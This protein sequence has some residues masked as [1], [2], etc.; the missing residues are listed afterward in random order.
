MSCA[1]A[2]PDMPQ[3]ISNNLPDFLR[4]ISVKV[5]VKDG[6]ISN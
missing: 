3:N 1:S 6:K 5:S 4:T 2:R